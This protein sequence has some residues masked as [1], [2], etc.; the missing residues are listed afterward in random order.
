MDNRKN[1]SRRKALKAG[2]ATLAVASL[3]TRVSHAAIPQ[4]TPGETKIVTIMGDYWHN[5]IAQER[6]IR[7]IFSQLKGARVYCVQANRFFTRELIQDADLLIAACYNSGISGGWTTEGVIVDPP[8]RTKTDNYI[9]DEMAQAVYDNVMNRGMGYLALHATVQIQSKKIYDLMNIV[10]DIQH[11]QIQPIVVRDINQDHPITKG[12][13]PFFINLD[14]QFDGYFKKNHSATVLF[15][16]EAVHD[17]RVS[18]GG[19]CNEAGNGRVVSLMPGHTQWPYRVP[20]Y[21]EIIWRAAHWALKRDIPPYNRS[22]GDFK[23]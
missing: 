17:G 5:K 21:Q 19:W 11:M 15:H 8:K 1:P 6:E 14:E 7:R 9:T 22:T 10:K 12:I 4:K 3:A 2:A 18:K 13:T 20:K 16:T 23:Q